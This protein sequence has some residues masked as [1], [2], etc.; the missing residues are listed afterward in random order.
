MRKQRF[1]KQIGVMLDDATYDLLVE[2]TDQQEVSVSEFVRNIM[3]REL[4]STGK[5]N[6]KNEG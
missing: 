5:E 2:A 3:E 6:D 1:V 4:T